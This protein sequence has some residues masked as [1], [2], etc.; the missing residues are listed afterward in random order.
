MI[1][2]GMKENSSTILYDIIT[3]P[4]YHVVPGYSFS[5]LRYLY[6]AFIY[7]PESV[8]SHSEI[9]TSRPYHLTLIFILSYPDLYHHTPDIHTVI[10][11]TPALVRSH[12]GIITLVHT[13]VPRI[14]FP[15]TPVSYPG[16]AYPCTL[17]IYPLVPRILSP[18]TPVS[19]PGYLF[20]R[21]PDIIPSYPSLVPRICIPSYPGYLS[22]RTPD[23]IPSYP[24]LIPRIF[25]PSYPRYYPLIPQSRTPD[26]H[27]LVPWIFIPS[28]HCYSYHLDPI[29]TLLYASI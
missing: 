8:N 9:N 7:T 20:L 14:L 21:T 12:P 10:P 16:Y 6:P 5:C 27:T 17:D 25:I 2:I 26:M 29:L 4:Q 23:I 1:I 18:R 19:Y 13:L 11:R 3:I 28:Y 15:C 22:P 24:G